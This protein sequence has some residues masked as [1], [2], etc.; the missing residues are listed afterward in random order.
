M[1]QGPSRVLTHSDRRKAVP[2]I[3]LLWLL[4]VLKTAN[5]ADKDYHP[6]VRQTIAMEELAVIS[7]AWYRKIDG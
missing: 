5:A 1:K 6:T 2:I 3:R 7:Q 4:N